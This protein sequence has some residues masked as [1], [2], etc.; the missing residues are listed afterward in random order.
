M[1]CASC[2]GC[3]YHHYHSCMWMYGAERAEHAMNGRTA[4]RQLGCAGKTVR[5]PHRFD[6]PREEKSWG[7]DAPVTLLGEPGAS[8]VNQLAVGGQAV[9]DWGE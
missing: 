9:M 8:S 4:Q 2:I 6:L 3:R 7:D 5:M 1:I